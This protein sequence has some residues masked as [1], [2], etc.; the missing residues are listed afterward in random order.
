MVMIVAFIGPAGSG[1]TSL[2]NAYGKWVKDNLWLRVAQVNLDPGAEILPYKPVFDIRS[3]FTIRDIMVKYNLGP[4]GAFIKAGELIAENT[5]S[6]M[7]KNPFNNIDEWDI[8]LID[9]PGQM[10]AFI[11]RPSSNILFEKLRSL[12]SIIGVFIIDATAITSLTDALVLWFLG[13]LT[14]IK[15]GL[16][17]V[18]VINKIDVAPNTEYAELLIKEPEKLVELAKQEET[19]EGLLSDLSHELTQIALK[20]RQALRP[21]KVSAKDGTG[22][23]EL[24]YLLHEVLCACGDLT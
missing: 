24:H 19:G 5:S 22:L 14:Q 7:E 21:V 11:F 4:N 8:I 12:G 1:K 18:P 13:L 16:P 6:I 2:V 17:I 20:T 23:D 10:E 15:T 3:M 9:T